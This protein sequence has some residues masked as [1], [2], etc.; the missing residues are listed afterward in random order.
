[1]NTIYTRKYKIDS[2]L[3]IIIFSLLSLVSCEPNTIEKQIEEL[4]SETE[5]NDIKQIAYSLA[6]SL[7]TKASELLIAKY[8]MQSSVKEKIRWG[9][10]GMISRYADINDSRI[11]ACLS[12]ITDPNP[13]HVLSNDNK[14]DL[15]IYGLKLY[16]TNDE[17][18]SI[19]SNSALKHNET[20]M[21]K[22]IEKWK[23]DRN[24]IALLDAIKIFDEK[25]LA[26]L[27]EI[28][29]E[30]EF[31]IDLLARIGEP[32]IPKMKLKM[33]SNKQSVRFA[34]GDVLVKMIEYHPDALSNLTSAIDNEGIKT[35]ANNYIFY[36]RL[37]QP[38][39]E[40]IIL[41]ALRYNFSLTMGLDLLNCGSNIIEEGAAKIGRENG[42]TVTSSVGSHPGPRWGSNN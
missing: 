13:I 23:L 5:K 27:S 1:M 40:K 38:G 4:V 41:K 32:S 21:L 42:Y 9:L 10:Q 24:S 11:E 31:A 16:R 28:I 7:D 14:L 36:I 20:G 8:P 30:D 19:L 26:Y 29:T 34:A 2:S 12:Y 22:L 18:K 3:F 15:I 25:V 33:R 39:T 37:G 6:D 35:I 17:F